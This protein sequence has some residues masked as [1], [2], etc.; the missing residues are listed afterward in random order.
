LI[1]FGGR[2][3]SIEVVLQALQMQVVPLER[4]IELFSASLDSPTLRGPEENRA[5]RYDKTDIRHFCLLKGVRVVSALNAMLE[6][7]R[8]GYIQEVGV[9]IRTV[10]EFTSHIEFV[11]ETGTEEHR[12]EVDR[13]LKAFF[14]DAQ[15]GLGAE[16]IRAQ[17]RQGLVHEKLGETLDIIAEQFS[18]TEG[19]MPAAKLYSNVYRVFSNYVHGK[20]PEIM[21]LFGG[22]P[23]RFHLNGMSGTRKDAENLNQIQTYI[24]L[25]SNTFV[26]MIKSLNLGGLVTKD[27]GVERWY[28]GRIEIGQ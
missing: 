9:L 15:R 17:V 6:L 28:K 2:I 24:E 22:V 26:I 4:V 1:G 14:A 18:K 16:I 27:Q 13:Y 8:S 10:A 12:A 7:A 3:V 19:W 21:D 11:L 20:Y 25:A 23:G 5:Y